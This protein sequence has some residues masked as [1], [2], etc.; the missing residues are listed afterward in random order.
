[1]PERGILV[2]L[3]VGISWVEVYEKLWGNLSLRY[4]K[5]SESNISN[6]RILWGTVEFNGTRIL[7]CSWWYRY[8]KKIRFSPRCWKVC[9]RGTFSSMYN[10]RFFMNI[11]TINNFNKIFELKI[12]CYFDKWKGSSGGSSTTVPQ[13]IPFLVPRLARSNRRN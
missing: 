4:L 2:C 8:T 11:Q 12:F 3:R 5:C 13:F 9:V 6:R 7:M 1:M 10:E